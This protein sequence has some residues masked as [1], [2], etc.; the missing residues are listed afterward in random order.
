MSGNVKS[1]K[2]REGADFLVD[3]LAK[4]AF[5]QFFTPFT[6]LIQR[7]AEIF[8][9]GVVTSSV[10]HQVWELLRKILSNIF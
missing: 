10:F 5:S 6:V 9:P 3:Y 1:P 2:K 7:L 8:L 4:Q